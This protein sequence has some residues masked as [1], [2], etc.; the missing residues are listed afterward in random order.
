VSRIS[1]DLLHH[2]IL[3]HF[4]DHGHA[5]SVRRLT[6]LLDAPHD[7]VRAAL[8][9]LQEY[10]GVVLHPGSGEIWVAHPFSTAPTNF[11]VESSAGRWWGNCAWCS[12]GIAALVGGE[13]TVTTRLGAESRQVQVRIVRGKVLDDYLVHFPVPMTRAWEN[14]IY[15]CSTILLFDSAAAIDDWC[16][17]HRIPKGDTKPLSTVF[18][19]SKVWYGRHLD[20]NWRKWSAAE[21][22]E[23]FERF[24]LSGPTWDIPQAATRF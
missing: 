10:H 11:W 14:V 23:L 12:M 3:T 22:K 20:R 16:T 1:H 9:S 2:T 17:R 18:E 13:V 24:G 8:E 6:E 19:F 7:A 5:P 15:T 21:A 4:V